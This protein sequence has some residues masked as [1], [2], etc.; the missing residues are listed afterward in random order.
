MLMNTRKAMPFG[1]VTLVLFI[2][3][4]GI[5]YWPESSCENL[6][7]TL[8]QG[9]FMSWQEPNFILVTKDK[10]QWHVQAES[11]EQACS[12]MQNQLQSQTKAS[13]P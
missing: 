2:L 12:A 4:V 1:L 11:K 10:A 6:K 8:E 9:F 3:A 13:K 5:K 7:S